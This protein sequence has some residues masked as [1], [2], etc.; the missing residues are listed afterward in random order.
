M[1]NLVLSNL[2]LREA[3]IFAKVYTLR[4][5]VR[6]LKKAGVS[7]AFKK[8]ACKLALASKKLGKV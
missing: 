4:K 6:R 8:A 5:Q 1:N 7:V 2:T 3:K